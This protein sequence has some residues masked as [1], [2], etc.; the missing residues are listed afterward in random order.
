MA[1]IRWIKITTDIFDDEK[2]KLIDCLPDR[3]TVIV[4]WFKL[5]AMAGK[6]NDNGLIYVIKSLPTTDEMLSTIFN[7]PLNTVRLA[8]TTFQE[9]G[10]ISV[11]KHISLENWER[12]QNVQGMEKIKE[13]TRLRVAKHRENQKEKECNVTVTLANA[14]EKRREDKIREDKNI[15]DVNI[16]KKKK[17]TS[18]KEVAEFLK[19]KWNE[20]ADLNGLAKVL[21]ISDSRQSKI[22]ARIKESKDF[23]A[24]FEEVIKKINVTPFLTGENN[25]GWKVDFDWIIENDKNYLKALEGKYDA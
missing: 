25:R 13:Q 22:N 5:L 19:D 12:H 8:L 20:N 1:D 4:I 23:K 10:M 11:E 9:F 24:I 7:R 18:Y 17:D 14:T 21:K 15:Q 2:I 16:E 6:V 3:D